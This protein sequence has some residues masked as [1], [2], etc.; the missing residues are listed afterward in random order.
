[1]IRPFPLLVGLFASSPRV[2]LELQSL[3]SHLMDIITI[4]VMDFFSR[5]GF[6]LPIARQRTAGPL[7]QVMIRWREGREV[8]KEQD[9]EG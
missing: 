7:R 8:G 5:E 6:R 2:Y 9:R 3:R 1:M 4:I